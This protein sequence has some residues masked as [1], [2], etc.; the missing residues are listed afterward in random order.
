[1]VSYNSY[2]KTKIGPIVKA[3]RAEY[4][5]CRAEYNALSDYARRVHNSEQAEI[6]AEINATHVN[7]DKIEL[8]KQ[9]NACNVLAFYA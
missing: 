9:L 6:L 8:S 2:Q 5:N 1:M 3:A 7:L 4:A